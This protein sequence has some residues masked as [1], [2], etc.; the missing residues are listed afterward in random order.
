MDKYS[1]KDKEKEKKPQD[2]VYLIFKGI[3]KESA[4][5]V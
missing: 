4:I 2:I 5:K 1:L 3:L